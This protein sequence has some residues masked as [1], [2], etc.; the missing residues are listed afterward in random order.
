MLA[1]QNE[2]AN[3]IVVDLMFI[4]LVLSA[5]AEAMCEGRNGQ[6]MVIEGV[7]RMAGEDSLTVAAWPRLV[8][9]RY[10]RGFEALD[11]SCRC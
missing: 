11:V 10:W 4:R 3:S 2:P 1:C 5:N 8:E 6:V 9:E 7:A